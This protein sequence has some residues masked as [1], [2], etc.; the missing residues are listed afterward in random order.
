M[1]IWL[2]LVIG[3]D[4]IGLWESMTPFRPK[5]ILRTPI[6]NLISNEMTAINLGLFDLNVQSLMLLLNTGCQEQLIM[7]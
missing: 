3:T 7:S 5:L 2:R 4:L 6:V 1:W